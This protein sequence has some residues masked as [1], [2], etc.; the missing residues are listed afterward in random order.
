LYPTQTELR[1][2]RK[3]QRNLP[4][5]IQFTVVEHNPTYQSFPISEAKLQTALCKKLAGDFCRAGAKVKGVLLRF[6]HQDDSFYLLA[7][8]R[9]KPGII[10]EY[11]VRRMN[12]CSSGAGASRNGGPAMAGMP[13]SGSEGRN[14][15]TARYGQ[16]AWKLRYD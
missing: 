11:K 7:L 1:F 6:A 10:T 15:A 16:G 9:K 12:A 5:L 2:D 3:L 8:E 13:V 4:L 14:R